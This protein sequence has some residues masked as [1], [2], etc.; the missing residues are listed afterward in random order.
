MTN[1]WKDIEQ[2]FPR[3]T[4]SLYLV[5]VKHKDSDFCQIFQVF[6]CHVGKARWAPDN[7]DTLEIRGYSIA[8]RNFIMDER[9]ARER[10]EPPQS[11]DLFASATHDD[12]P[13]IFWRQLED[14]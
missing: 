5:K 12:R 7:D 13:K 10:R 2:E 11:G 3:D 8:N 4:E 1:G 6:L 14:V 9:I